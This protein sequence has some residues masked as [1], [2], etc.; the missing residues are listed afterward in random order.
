MKQKFSGGWKGS[1]QARKQRKYRFN[2]PL[3]IKQKFTSAHLSKELRKKYNLRSI[4]L[5]KG[6]KVKVM[7][8]QFKKHEGKVESIDLKKERIVVNGIEVAKKDG[9]KTTYP[10]H[11]SNLMIIELSTDDKMRRK[12]L[13]RG[14]E[15]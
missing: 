12:R 5:R 9:T 3:H 7:R 2:A 8:G 13:E 1:K 11:P 6:D 15:K 4:G 10:I 14:K